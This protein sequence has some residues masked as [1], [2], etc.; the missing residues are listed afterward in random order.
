MWL[1]VLSGEDAGRV[2]KVDRTLVLGRVQGAD[3]VIRDARASRRHLELE[4]VAGG[5]ALRDLGSANGTLVDGEPALAAL[6]RGGEV[7]RVGGVRIAVLA[8]EPAATG[9]P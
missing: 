4:P 8:Q 9:A 6:L 2:V 1:E 7:I 5:I 3:L